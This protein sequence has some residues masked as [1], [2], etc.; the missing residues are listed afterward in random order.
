[1]PTKGYWTPNLYQALE[2]LNDMSATTLE[3]MARY[4]IEK[5]AIADLSN[6]QLTEFIIAKQESISLARIQIQAAEHTLRERGQKVREIQAK[7]S[8]TYVPPADVQQEKL[9]KSL[10]K[11]GES[12]QKA[13]DFVEKVKSINIDDI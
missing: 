2:R 6:E 13:R 11:K 8:L 1:M 7:E 10:V 5:L 12:A 4:N 3:F 9:F